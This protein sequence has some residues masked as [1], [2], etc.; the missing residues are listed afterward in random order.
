MNENQNVVE[1]NFDIM[2]HN[3]RIIGGAVRDLFTIKEPISK[4][5]SR[6][7]PRMRARFSRN[8]SFDAADTGRLFAGWVTNNYSL[9]SELKKDL[10]LIR[11]R[12]REMERNNDYA[13]KFFGLLKTNIVGSA[14]YMGIRPQS[15]V[16]KN[17]GDPDDSARKKIEAAWL[18]FCKKGNCDV[19]GQYTMRDIQK[20]TVSGTARD[21]EL[22]FRRMIGFDNPYRYA[23]QLLE[24]DHLDI[25]KNDI[26]P[27]G[28]RVKMGIEFDEFN[29]RVAY[30]L[31]K[32]HP[33]D[34]MFGQHYGERIR[35]PADEIIHVYLP[36]RSAQTR[37]LPWMHTALTRLNQLGDYELAELVAS[38]LSAAK[39]GFYTSKTGDEEALPVTKWEDGQPIQEVEPGHYEMLPPGIDFKP[40]DP[41]HPTTA[42]GDFEK[43]IL[44]GIASGLG[45]SYT[46]LANDLEGV[47][48]SSIRAGL[49]DERD[50]Y[51]DIQQ[52]HIEH[53]LDSVFNE[54]LFIALSRGIIN[55]PIDKFDKFK[56]VKWQTRGW[57]W[58][59]PMKEVNAKAKSISLGLD[60]PQDA[61]AE[62]GKEYEDN[63]VKIAESQKLKTKYKIK[64]E[65]SNAPKT[66]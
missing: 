39:G 26:L 4:K 22:L 62:T 7:F 12:S 66:K 44:R 20:L 33:G 8:N 25:K 28:N 2:K 30:W 36:I 13:K 23:L 49:L 19:T 41:T 3:F 56:A 45:V 24:P 32:I 5:V 65:V 55:L 17:N 16:V 48:Y 37:G 52:F 50:V 27:N 18:D 1:N 21:G 61:A 9:D 10:P 15:R 14:G 42:F 34:S 46:S 58:V 38:R 11:A 60:N 29:R 31:F 54:W 43:A 53:W 47:N 64:D 6:M 59:D 63:I 57:Q 51:R 35:V 40:F